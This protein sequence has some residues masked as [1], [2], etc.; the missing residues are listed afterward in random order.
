MGIKESTN[1]LNLEANVGVGVYMYNFLCAH[2]DTL[3]M[4]NE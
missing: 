1:R 3:N 2:I 4:Q